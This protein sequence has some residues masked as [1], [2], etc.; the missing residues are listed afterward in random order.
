MALTPPSPRIAVTI[1][2]GLTSILE[3]SL[4]F[5]CKAALARRREPR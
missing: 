3:A 4:A 2:F 1:V 5:A